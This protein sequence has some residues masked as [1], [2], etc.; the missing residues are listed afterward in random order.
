[1]SN[2]WK[3]SSVSVDVNL[4]L[5]RCSVTMVWLKNYSYKFIVKSAIFSLHG[6]RMNF[7]VARCSFVD[8]AQKGDSRSFLEYDVKIHFKEML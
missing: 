3:C 8:N 7:V 5:R 4:L 2:L 6:F 1:V